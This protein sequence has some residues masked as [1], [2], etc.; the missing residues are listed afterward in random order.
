MNLFF[1]SLALHYLSIRQ[2]GG[3]LIFEI[4]FFAFFA[5]RDIL[6]IFVVLAWRGQYF[7]LG[8][9][10]L[11]VIFWLQI[12]QVW[13]R[14]K[15]G[16]RERPCKGVISFALRHCMLRSRRGITY[17]RGVLYIYISAWAICVAYLCEQAMR[18]PEAKISKS[19]DSHV[20]FVI[21]TM[22]NQG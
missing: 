10:L 7:L 20:F 15:I 5:C 4:F 12:S 18:E 1:S 11:S 22:S 8:K 14:R 3:G 9:T 19:T 13:I 21:S 17:R 6:I 2:T 16:Q